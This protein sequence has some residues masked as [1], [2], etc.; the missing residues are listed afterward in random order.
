MSQQHEE[1][2]HEETP[3][4]SVFVSLRTFI[5]F[6]LF[7]V[8]LILLTS[9]HFT[10]ATA[11]NAFQQ[12]GGASAA[13]ESLEGPP[14]VSA[15]F[16]DRML[17]NAGSPAAGTGEALYALG[18]QYGIDPAYA[19]AFFHHESGYGTT[20]EAT[21]TRSLGNERC[22]ADRPCNA[23][24]F[25]VF[26][27]WQDGEAHWYFLIRSLYIGQWHLSTVEQI[28][29]VYAPSRDHNDVTAYIRAIESDVAAYR[30]AMAGTV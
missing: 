11:R 14:T 18:V 13:G 30:H 23:Q 6:D 16:I 15:A 26:Q 21:V 3:A 12:A 4:G 22:I 5:L 25:A 9:S 27:S 28:I 29:P 8:A 10:P 17:A 20:G 2:E 1:Q 24:H 19:L 7:V